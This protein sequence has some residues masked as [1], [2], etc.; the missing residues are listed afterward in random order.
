MKTILRRI[1][2]LLLVLI[3]TLGLVCVSAHASE[4][5]FDDSAVMTESLL[6]VDQNTGEVLYSKNADTKRAM[7]STVKI[8]TAV[9]ALEE[10]ENPEMYMI[11]IEEKPI[12][13]ITDLDASTA[14]FEYHIGEEFSALD[15]IYG[16]MLPSGCEAAQI[17]A[18]EIGSTLENFADMMN[19]KAEEL[20]CENTYFEEG[21]GLSDNNYTTAED[22][23]KIAQYA[24]KNETFREIVSTEYYEIEGFS[25]PI[26]NTNYLIA[27]ENNNGYYYKYCTGIKTGFTTLSGRCLVSQAKKGDDEFLCVALGGTYSADDGYI[28]HAMVDSVSLYEW[29]F[30]HHTEN[31]NVDIKQDFA[32]V[33]IDEK[34]SVNVDADENA[35]IKWT[36]SNESVATVDSSGVVTGKALG[37]AKITATAQTGNFDTIKVSV[38]FYNGIDVTSRYGDYTTG[39]KQ[40]LDWKAV[41]D[42][43]FDFA[44]IRAGWGSEDYPNQND[45]EFVNNVQGAYENDIPYFLSFIAYAQSEEEAKAEADYFLREMEEYFPKNCK[46]GLLDVVY[47]MTYSPYSGNDK[48]LNTKIALAFADRIK[49]RGFDTLIF[50]NKSV[51]NN[52]DTT[53]LKG[54]GVGIYYSYYPYIVDFNEQITLPDGTTP[55]MWQF[56]SDG[57]FP[58]ASENKYAKLCIAYIPQKVY[59]KLDVDRDGMVTVMDATFIQRVL[60]QLESAE[61]FDSYGD[62]DGDSRVS[63]LD[64]TYIQR[65]LAEIV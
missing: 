24:M 52:L 49:E 46:D 13:D 65:H 43:G 4:V 8:M 11:K 25:A 22:L 61:G 40:P 5:P 19:D 41:K 15:I 42:S 62:V 16:V 20:G 6:L 38:G 53:A 37:Q 1:S 44:V 17:L 56:R 32:S 28:N 50:S 31:V 2:I 47:N 10:I 7:A 59:D 36:S 39:E 29:A 23:A 48:E 45:A 51:Y 60:A 33:E 64:A 14:G 55:D 21:H 58:S 27:E 18:Y 9:L 3:L 54:N 26:Y 57:Y 34:L 12:S 63:I 30:E 35:Q